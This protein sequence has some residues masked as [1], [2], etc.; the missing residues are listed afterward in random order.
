M[1]VSTCSIKICKRLSKVA[2]GTKI[3]IPVVY[4]ILSA[5]IV[6]RQD[7]ITLLLNCFVLFFLY[8]LIFFFFFFFVEMYQNP[9]PTSNGPVGDISSYG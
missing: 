7:I 2:I 5:N 8:N 4:D 6:L 1:F 9:L 3:V